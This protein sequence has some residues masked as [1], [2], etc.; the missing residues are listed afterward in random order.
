MRGSE[1]LSLVD[2]IEYFCRPAGKSISSQGKQRK[3]MYE[4]VT[5]ILQ[6]HQY[7]QQSREVKGLLRGYSAK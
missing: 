3:E 2:Q 1:K 6:Q 7:R 5:A 4:W